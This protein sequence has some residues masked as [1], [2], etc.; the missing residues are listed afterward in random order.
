MREVEQ[1][2][3]AGE[4]PSTI[5]T[6]SKSSSPVYGNIAVHSSSVR[7]ACMHASARR[8]NA[9]PHERADRPIRV[10]RGRPTAIHRTEAFAD[11]SRV[12][13]AGSGGD[14]A[15]HRLGKSEPGRRRHRVLD[16]APVCLRPTTGGGT[17]VRC[18][19]YAIVSCCMPS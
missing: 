9:R 7:P 15:I 17:S 14:A 11:T 8:C 1:G 2:G 13:P 6:I 16:R 5:F 4:D 3:A 18:I 12:G 19:L 10:A